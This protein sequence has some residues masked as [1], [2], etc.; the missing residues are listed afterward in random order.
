MRTR[1]L[2][3]MSRYLT[4]KHKRGFGS[5]FKEGVGNLKHR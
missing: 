4:L 1:K 2:N 3:I 5:E